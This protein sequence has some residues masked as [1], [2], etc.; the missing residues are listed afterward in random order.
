MIDVE[1]RVKRVIQTNCCTKTY[2]VW[3]TEQVDVTTEHEAINYVYDKYKPMEARI[4][5]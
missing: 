3:Q 5:E 4:K 2:Y 1:Y